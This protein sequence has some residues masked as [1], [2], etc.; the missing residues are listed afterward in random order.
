MTRLK[1]KYYYVI[2]FSSTELCTDT[3]DKRDYV[4]FI[5]LGYYRL[6]VMLYHIL[7]TLYYHDIQEYGDAMKFINIAL[8]MEPNNSQAKELKQLIKHKQNQGKLV[9]YCSYCL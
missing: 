2:K 1:F 5:S 7:C 4:Y 6:K 3:G 8:K 9:V